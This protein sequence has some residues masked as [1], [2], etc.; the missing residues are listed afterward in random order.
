M[1]IPSP[2]TRPDLAK[3]VIYWVPVIAPGNLMFY[4]GGL[5]PQWNGSAI[6]SGLASNALIRILFDGKGGARTAERWDVGRRV[7][8]VEVA[9][10]GALWMIE[11]AKPGGL[12]R[13]TPLGKAVSAP[14]AKPATP[15]SARSGSATPSGAATLNAS[16]AEH[17]KSV[18]ADNSCI[19][20]H[21]IGRNGGEIGPSLNGVGARLTADLIRA[22]IVNPPATTSAGTPNPM[23]SYKNK[24]A[25]EDLNSLVHYLSTLPALR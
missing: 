11:D 6:A 9:P 5:F 19:S 10:D 12:F 4:K 3:P 14:A 18:I 1:P 15:A 13:L 17:V 24:I 21:R 7:R 20:C 22:A 2:D 16:N 25:E 8:D 23:P